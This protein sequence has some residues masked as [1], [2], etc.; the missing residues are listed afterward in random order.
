MCHDNVKGNSDMSLC[1]T[2]QAFTSTEQSFH[3][4]LDI[5]IV[6]LIISFYVVTELSQGKWNLTQT[7]ES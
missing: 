7:G 1:Q 2:E 6:E 4:I 5:R 3:K